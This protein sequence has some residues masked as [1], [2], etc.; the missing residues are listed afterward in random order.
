M[1]RYIKILTLLFCL[2]PVFAI[3]QKKLT[4]NG[5]APQLRDGTEISL[6]LIL[7]KTLKNSQKSFLAKVD[8]HSFRFVLDVEGAE[9]YR[10]KANGHQAYA[11]C[12]GP[13]NAGITISDSILRKVYIT[14]NETAIEYEKYDSDKV[15]TV[16][17][18]RYLWARAHRD[19]YLESKGI[20]SNILKAKNREVDSLETIADKNGIKHC[21][22]WIKEYP[23]SYINTKILYDQLSI[24]P[25]DELKKTFLGLPV[26]IKSNSWGK[27]LKYAVDN[28]LVGDTPPDFSEADTSGRQ[29]SLSTFRGKYTLIDFWASWCK[30]CREE[31][32]YLATA[33]KKY[34]SRNFTI[35]SISLDNKREA[36]LKAINSDGLNWT[37]LCDLKGL[38]NPVSTSYFITSIPGNYLIDPHGKIIARNLRGDQLTFFLD[39]LNL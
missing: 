32:P 12:L 27:E 28:L 6:D 33:M 29:V 24:M 31:T 2:I 14:G 35:L 36:W 37:H 30:P 7:P 11:F 3:S 19:D 17:K 10:L 5:T 20:D 16:F 1:T 8:K 23:D 18:S 22:D 34:R 39:S 4:I 9:F 26:H 38:G 21:L 15:Q 13:G 25:D